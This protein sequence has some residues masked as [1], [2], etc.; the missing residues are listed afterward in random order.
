LDTLIAILAVWMFISPWVLAYGPADSWNTWI[1]SAI[2]FL[3][4]L[5]A[6]TS[7]NVWHERITLVLGAWMFISPW[8]LGF[9]NPTAGASWNQWLVGALFFLIS[10][11]AMAARRG[12]GMADLRHAHGAH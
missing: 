1:V 10:L 9:S 3:T 5:S 8:V 4:A 12:V 6:L 2:I 11:G 7:A